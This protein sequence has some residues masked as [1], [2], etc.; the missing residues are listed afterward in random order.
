MALLAALALAAVVA[1]SPARPSASR[2]RPPASIE[3]PRDHLTAYV[4][5]VLRYRREADRTGIR[6]R[7]D[8]NT[9]EDVTIV[10]P[11]AD[12]GRW[13][14]VEGRPFQAADAA[15]IEE[16]P[17]QLRAGVRAAAWVCDD[18]RNPVVD[19]TPPRER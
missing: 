5:V 12:P 2:V 16:R 10:H 18:G 17:G 4:G 7:T 19:W 9:T 11:G 15:L 1:A 14:L 6:I 13:F 3:C 8:W